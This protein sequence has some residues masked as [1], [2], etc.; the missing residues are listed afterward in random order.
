[1]KRVTIDGYKPD[2]SESGF[3]VRE[4]KS[5]EVGSIEQ[6]KA[7]AREEFS[8]LFNIWIYDDETGRAR[9]PLMAVWHSKD[10]HWENSLQN[11]FRWEHW[12]EWKQIFKGMK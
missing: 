1:M 5:F 10:S 7:L 6:A 2:S 3:F 8:E 9:K 12:R 4:Y 11:I